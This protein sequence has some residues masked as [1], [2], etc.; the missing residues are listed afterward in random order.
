MKPFDIEKALAG[1]PLVTRDGLEVTSIAP[2]RE[3][4]DLISL[5]PY[6]ITTS[7]ERYS[8]TADGKYTPFDVSSR[9]V[10]LADIPAPYTLPTSAELSR[11]LHKADFVASFN[12]VLHAAGGE[13]GYEANKSS[14][15]E[16]LANILAPNGVRFCHTD[17]DPVEDD[18]TET[19]ALLAKATPYL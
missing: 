6:W 15:L 17:I 7:S 14:T 18:A 16:E 12:A 9:D 5:Y 4:D 13:G 2:K 10:F 1:H 19:A 3:N 11:A 8:I